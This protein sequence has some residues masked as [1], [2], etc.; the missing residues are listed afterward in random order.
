L[1]TADPDVLLELTKEHEE[2]PRNLL[3]SSNLERTK[4]AA[5]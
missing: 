1:A 2:S 4:H 5:A 3:E